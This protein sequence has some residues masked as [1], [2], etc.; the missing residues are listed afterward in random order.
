MCVFIINGLLG[1]LIVCL[2]ENYSSVRNRQIEVAFIDA[3]F[4]SSSCVYGCGLIT[5]DFAKLSRASQIILMAFTFIPGNTISTLPAL[6]IKAAAHKNVEGRAVDDDNS[7]VEEQRD[8]LPILDSRGA[9]NLPDHIRNRLEKLPTPAQLRYRAYIACIVLIL[10]TCFAI[11]AITFVAIGGWLTTQ[12]TPEQLLQENSSVNPWYTSF[13]ITVTGFNQNGLTPFSDDFARFVSDV[14]LN[15]FAALIV[16]CGTSLFPYILRNVVLIVRRL[17]PWRHKVIFDYVLL[18]NHRLSTLL[19]PTLQTRIYLFITLLLY[20]LVNTRFAGFASIDVSLLS[21]ATL[22]V[23][24]LL[25]ANKPQMLCALDETPFELSWLALETQEK[26]DAETKPMEKNYVASDV[27][28]SHNQLESIESG[29]TR[30]AL[31]V[32]QMHQFFHRRITTTTDQARVQFASTT[33]KFNAHGKTRRLKYLRNRLFFFHFTRTL[34]KNAITSIILTRTWLIFFIFRICAIEYRQMAPADPNITLL[35]IIFETMSAFGTVGLSLGYPNIV[36]SFATVLSP[37]SKVILIATMLMG[38]HRGLLASMKDQETIEYSAF[39]L[40]NR[41][42][43][44]LICEYEKTTLGY[45]SKRI[46]KERIS[47]I[48][49]STTVSSEE[50]TCTAPKQLCID[51]EDTFNDYNKENILD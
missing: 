42:R 37:A 47:S 14:Y 46:N 19:F 15:L 35:K 1:G 40:L 33:T 31:P 26:V 20:I 21:T 16:I 3:W 9:R 41:E 45:I 29:P 27:P 5:L 28:A 32:A 2:I 36:S 34:R 24:L 4:T 51:V 23:Y 7:N 12:Y 13:I 6:I 48:L 22:L 18:N 30:H 38:R 25:M 43:L 50:S 8:E 17:S 44:K 11:Y 10:V 49:S 39:D